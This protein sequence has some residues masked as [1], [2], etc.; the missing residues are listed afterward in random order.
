MILSR[1]V[2][3]VE[4]QSKH[5]NRETVGPNMKWSGLR[6]YRRDPVDSSLNY[7]N[8]LRLVRSNNPVQMVVAS[9]SNLL[10]DGILRIMEGNS[11]IN[12]AAQTSEAQEV[13][14]Y[15]A[16]IKPRILFIDNRTLGL[17]IEKLSSL[18]PRKSP[19]TRVIL[20]GDNIKDVFFLPNALCVTKETDSSELIR[21]IKNLSRGSQNDEAK[22]VDSSKNMFTK[23]EM[24]IIDLMSQC[25]IN[26]EMAKK[27]SISEK[28]VKAHLSNIFEKLGIQSRYQLIVYAR[29]LHSRQS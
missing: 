18:I 28:T 16:E 26:R 9:G 4:G 24:K 29:R 27:L 2:K 1:T 13:G 6:D 14:K 10:L 22:V 5:T 23:T 7:D 19:D 21:I 3:Q 15:L 20:F 12:I 11:E 25:L 8:Q 17:D